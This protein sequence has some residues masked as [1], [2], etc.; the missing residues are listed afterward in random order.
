LSS[1]GEERLQ[2]EDVDA[3][4]IASEA[5]AL[6]EPLAIKKGLRTSA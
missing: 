2:I 4:L 1:P 5:Q 6:L 3:T